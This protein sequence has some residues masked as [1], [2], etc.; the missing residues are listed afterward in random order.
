MGG[1]GMPQTRTPAARVLRLVRAHAPVDPMDLEIHAEREGIGSNEL[2]GSL[3]QLL[4]EAKI[5][6]DDVDIVAA[7]SEPSPRRPSAKQLELEREHRVRDAEADPA[8]Q[9]FR[10][11][12]LPG[13]LLH[14]DK[15]LVQWLQGQAVGQRDEEDTGLPY[16][17]PDS[18]WV[19]WLPVCGPVHLE[20]QRLGRRLAKRYDWWQAEATVFVLSGRVPR[21]P[22]LVGSLHEGWQRDARGRVEPKRP[23]V[24]IGYQHP[25]V[26]PE[27]VPAFERWLLQK[28][29]QAKPRRR[30]DHDLE[31]QYALAEFMCGRES[32]QA[33]MMDWNAR[34]RGLGRP[35]WTARDR[36]NFRA[37]L[38]RARATT[39]L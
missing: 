7:P 20:L 22:M 39:R 6:V 19:L 1:A 29:L 32:T 36:S 26:D 23:R 4:A 37:A 8:V 18:P 2:A 11:Q 35:E 25:N 5:T 33:E 16:V 15:T 34:C 27:A 30:P 17:L 28:S 13:A 9:R 31:R 21:A 10:E 14:W 38:D 24:T 12:H 3:D